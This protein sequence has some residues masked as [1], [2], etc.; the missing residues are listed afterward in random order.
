[1]GEATDKVVALAV[2]R[3]AAGAQKYKKPVGTKISDDEGRDANTRNSI[4]ERLGS[5][6]KSRA[7][8]IKELAEG[9]VPKTLT[10]AQQVLLYRDRIERKRAK[11]GHG[12]QRVTTSKVRKVLTAKRRTETDK[13]R[14]RR[15]LGVDID[16]I[17]SGD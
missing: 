11:Q 5:G 7:Q 14:I 2:V 3:T 6:G 9:P 16:R 1:M 4:L 8:V 13:K 12:A 10:P 15:V 17:K